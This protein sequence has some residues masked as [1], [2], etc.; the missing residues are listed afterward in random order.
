MQWGDLLFQDICTHH[1]SLWPL[2]NFLIC[3]LIPFLRCNN[4]EASI[5]YSSTGFKSVVIEKTG[6]FSSISRTRAFIFLF[7]TLQ[8]TFFNLLSPVC[9]YG[10]LKNE[11]IYDAHDFTKAS[12][13]KKR[14]IFHRFFAFLS[15]FIL[16]SKNEYSGTKGL[17]EKWLKIGGNFDILFPAEEKVRQNEHHD[18]FCQWCPFWALRPKLSCVC[19]SRVVFTPSNSLFFIICWLQ[20]QN[21]F[22]CL[23]S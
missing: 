21:S 6:L 3:F 9:K 16:A 19:A 20:R 13:E 10:E 4:V 8:Q 18:Y 17:L 1:A 12:H 14:L 15:R 22:A 23:I 7:L 2:P 11:A 5:R